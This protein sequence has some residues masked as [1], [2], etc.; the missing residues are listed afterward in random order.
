MLK[1]IQKRMTVVLIVSMLLQLFAGATPVLAKD[2]SDLI[3]DPEFV[4]MLTVTLSPG[5]TE[6]ATSATVTDYVYGN[7]L[8]NITEQEIE[9][10]RI[11]DTAP[12]TGDNLIAD[13]KSG[14]DITAG[15]IVG[16][17]LQIYDVDMEDG[18][19]IVA[20]YQAELTEEDIK[21]DI[22]EGAEE[23][24]SESQMMDAEL[25]AEGG[26]TYIDENGDTKFTGT[27]TVT[28][29]TS[30]TATLNGGWYIMEGIINRTGTITVSGN[31]HLIL[32]DN[33]SLTVRGGGAGIHV[34]LE[35]SLTIYAQ[36]DGDEMG[37]L[38]ATGG[39]YCAGIGGGEFVSSGVITING[40]VVTATGGDYA[41]GIGGGSRGS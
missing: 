18:A 21:E 24:P 35:N 27:K 15:V 38:H 4:P 3:A 31:V 41:A 12:T 30:G 28:R 14:A 7:L 22:E 26:Y 36:S 5:E 34:F 19:Q 1:M 32:A 11:G 23:E 13:Y 8:V 17:Y 16:N 40:G 10:P 20:F 33:S 9:I 25:M 37:S 39:N 6:G 29:I 2:S